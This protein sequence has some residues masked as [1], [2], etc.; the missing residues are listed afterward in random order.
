SAG[1]AKGRFLSCSRPELAHGRLREPPSREYAN[2]CNEL[3]AE[4]APTE[5]LAAQW[6]KATRPR[7]NR[8]QPY[9]TDFDGSKAAEAALYFPGPE[10]YS[11]GS[12]IGWAGTAEASGPGPA[13]SR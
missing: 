4:D 6:E 2:P 7:Q 1:R 5:F 8:A 13:P 3:P 11:C 10:R 12:A 9:N